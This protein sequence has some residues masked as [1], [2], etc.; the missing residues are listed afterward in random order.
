M[1]GVSTLVV[2][3]DVRV[4][5]ASDFDEFTLLQIKMLSATGVITAMFTHL[6]VMGTNSAQLC[7]NPRM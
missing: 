4:F 3:L 5:R 6:E 1:K 2:L 7:I